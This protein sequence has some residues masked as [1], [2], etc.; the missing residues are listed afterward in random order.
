MEKKLAIASF[1]SPTSTKSEFLFSQRLLV[2]QIQVFKMILQTFRGSKGDGK[3]PS[4]QT[5]CWS[6]SFPSLFLS[7]RIKKEGVLVPDGIVNFL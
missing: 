6:F 3:L 5:D 1:V 7:W 2:G 4:I